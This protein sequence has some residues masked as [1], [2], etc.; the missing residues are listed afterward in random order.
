MLSTRNRQQLLVLA[1]IAILLVTAFCLAA[2]IAYSD[3][4]LESPDGLSGEPLTARIAARFHAGRHDG[5]VWRVAPR[6]MRIKISRFFFVAVAVYAGTMALLY[7]EKVWHLLQTYM[8][9]PRHP[10]NLAVFRIVL[11]GILLRF[12]ASDHTSWWASLPEVLQYSPKTGI[13]QWGLLTRWSYWPPLWI[14]SDA[15]AVLTWLFRFFCWTALLGIFSRTSAAA[16]VLLGLYVLGLPQWFGKV[17]HYHHV[18]WFSGILA[19]SRCGDALS[20]D[21]VINAWRRA[22][23]GLT[24]P[25][26]AS[27]RYG[28]PVAFVWILI[29]IIYF[30]PGFYKWWTCGADWFTSDNFKIILY[31]KWRSIG[32]GWLPMFRIDRYPLLYRTGALF[33]IV[34]EL[35]FIFA[36]FCRPTR[37]VFAAA[38]ILFHITTR[39]TMKIGF[40]SL[41]FAYVVFF[42]WHHFFTDIGRRL[43][44]RQMF[45]LY[46]GNCKLCRRTIA[47]LRIFDVFERI[48]WLNVM[49]GPAVRAAGLA[50]LDDAATHRD[51]HAVVDRTA[52]AGFN[53][54]RALSARIPVLWPTLPLLYV[55][56]VPVIGSKIY[57]RVA[58]SRLCSI[59]QPPQ[60]RSASSEASTSSAWPK[61]TIVVGTLFVVGNLWCGTQ[62]LMDA[63]P[64]A[65]YPTF[66]SFR[67][68][69]V[70]KLQIETV[71]NDG[72]TNK[73]NIKEPRQLNST[74]GYTLVG[75]VLATEDP[76]VRQS[77][78]TSLWKAMIRRGVETPESATIRFSKVEFASD[79]ARWDE[80][81]LTTTVLLEIEQAVLQGPQ[82]HQD[83]Q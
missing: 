64:L 71:N 59:A 5:Q 77:R 25:P 81:P 22:D 10:I 27:V 66:A 6:P 38:G 67:D 73:L 49:D 35:G 58:D 41:S 63:W 74:R 82:E 76:H 14:D 55:W 83:D 30:F 36:I 4:A 43:M 60:E 2:F 12:F 79:P 75:R 65:A 37:A 26:G 21:A 32:D 47:I 56:P 23:R 46:D 28:V 69:T 61:A 62:N 31:N 78:L 8:Q 13:P 53:A 70:M 50:W 44:P 16:A 45:V 42:N 33:A 34:F 18:I 48:T 3:P 19:V 29:G 40:Y 7:R 24:Q 57:R 11:F 72:E 39:L 15:L 54:Y 9:T 80:P 51:M 20:I 1:T 68:P 52:W 17:N